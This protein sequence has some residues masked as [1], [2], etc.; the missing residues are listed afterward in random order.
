MKY[1]LGLVLFVV[2][3]CCT[4]VA[5]AQSDND[6]V[7]LEFDLKN[8]I[9]PFRV[10][11]L[12]EKGVALSSVEESEKD[13]FDKFVI[14]KF[15]N[16]FQKQWTKQMPLNDEL[17]YVDHTFNEDYLWVLF[18]KT[19]REKDNNIQLFRLSCLDGSWETIGTSIE[20]IRSFKKMITFGQD[21][22]IGIHSENRAYPAL[23]QSNFKERKIVEIWQSNNKEEKLHDI[24]RFKDELVL[25]SS[26]EMGR[27]SRLLMRKFAINQDRLISKESRSSIFSYQI[28]FARYLINPE[29]QEPFITGTYYPD[30]AKNEDVEY[31]NPVI[32]SGVFVGKLHNDSIYTSF[33]SFS[34][35]ENFYRYFETTEAVRIK[36]KMNRKKNDN[37]ELAVGFQLLLNEPY[38]YDEQL[39]FSGVAFSEKYKTVSTLGYDFYGRPINVYRE[40]FNGYQYS[41]ALIAAFGNQGEL[42]WNNGFEI[43]N[44]KLMQL[45]NFPMF[46]HY[47]NNTVIAYYYQGK[48]FSRIIK[49]SETVDNY[50][51][52]PIA[53]HNP[54][55]RLIG[56]ENARICL[57]YDNYFLVY[58]YQKI[59][60]NYQLKRNK[61]NVFFMNKIA[62]E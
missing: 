7:R 30:K 14:Q 15:D 61:D 34:D 16:D 18:L 12:G 58:G 23:I 40:V 1:I 47:G 54:M 51:Q 24:H 44:V 55:D 59:S 4:Y 48:I 11:P 28:T 43:R 25:L 62:F 42:V 56:E 19:G 36:K 5:F 45:K 21:V 33:N 29:N 32:A 20:K 52:I 49:R 53:F 9:K 17:K 35:F 41:S 46:Y 22:I 39:I 38:F 3:L 57:W 13:G 31:D 26:A 37:K 50:A 60:N 6:P 8:N 10:F 27:Q 2:M